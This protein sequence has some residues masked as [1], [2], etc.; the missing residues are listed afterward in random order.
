MTDA[1]G[2]GLPELG[3]FPG[4]LLTLT[5]LSG[6]LPVTL[7]RRLPAADTYKV[8]AVKPLKRDNLLQTFYR[9]GVRGLCLTTAAKSL[10]QVSWP[11][12]FLPYLSSSTETNYLKS[13][14]ACR[15]YPHRMA[16]VLVTMPNAL[17]DVEL[18][19]T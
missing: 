12:Q 18:R 17:L 14:L 13:E 10:L 15:L 19:Q 1:C 5:A 4:L 3:T 16:E 11:D 2:R 6:E 8:Y 9:N 7:V